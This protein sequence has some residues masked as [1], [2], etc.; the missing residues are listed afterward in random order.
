[1]FIITER[2]QV[3]E[4]VSAQHSRIENTCFRSS[5][6][7][8]RAFSQQSGAGGVELSTSPEKK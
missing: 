3:S 1:M 6:R 8:R 5:R 7:R 4:H 2:V